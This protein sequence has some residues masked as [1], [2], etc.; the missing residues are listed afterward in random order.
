MVPAVD[1]QL[2]AAE[3]HALQK[4]E[5]KLTTYRHMSRAVP[6]VLANATPEE[7]AALRASAPRLLSVVQDHVWDRRFA[8]VMAP[9]YGSALS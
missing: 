1:S 2:S 7:A 6:W 3:Q 8:H 4:E 5:A 9:L